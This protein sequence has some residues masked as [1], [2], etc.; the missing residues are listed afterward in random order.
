MKL[1][2]LLV[3]LSAFVLLLGPVAIAAEAQTKPKLEKMVFVHYKKDL[4]R[5]SVKPPKGGGTTCYT[6]NSNGAKLIAPANYVIDT[7]NAQG[8]SAS[9]FVGAINAGT[10]EWDK[11]TSKSLFGSYALDSNATW[12][13]TAPDGRN[14][15]V[16]A[17]YAQSDVIAITVTWGWFNVKPAERRIVEFDVMFD[18]DYNWGDGTTGLMDLQAIATHEIGHGIGMGDMYSDT[19]NLETM[20]GYSNYG[21]TIK[22][23]LNGGDILGLRKLYG[24]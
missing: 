15:F 13:G 16:F 3:I 20:Y 17:N 8:I 10:A 4:A 19:C 14:E 11:N 23:D 6:F 2:S 21:E 1:K 22:R 24:I 7:D 18:S 9:Q 5:A 12:D